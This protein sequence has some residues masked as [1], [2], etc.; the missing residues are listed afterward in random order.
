MRARG[1]CGHRSLVVRVQRLDV[2]L[3]ER[4]LETPRQTDRCRLL[5]ALNF[6][7]VASRTTDLLRELANA[8]TGGE[9]CG[10]EVHAA[11]CSLT[12][13]LLSSPLLAL[14]LTTG[15]SLSANMRT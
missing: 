12:A 1:S 7:Q 2:Q 3:R 13:N 11:Q 9:A 14:R 4:R 8:E 6:A 5:P 10:C 15:R